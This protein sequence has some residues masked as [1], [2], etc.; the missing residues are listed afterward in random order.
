MTSTVKLHLPGLIR[1]ASNPRMLKIRL[2]GFFFEN[3]LHWQFEVLLLL[4]VFTVC[5]QPR[6]LVVGVSDY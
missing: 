2:I 3:G 4:R 6:G 5:D 1:T